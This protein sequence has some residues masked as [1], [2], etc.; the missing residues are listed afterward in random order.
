MSC[1]GVHFALAPRDIEALLAASSDAARLELIQE[2]I[3]ERYLDDAN[4]YAAQTD[5]AWDA[6]HR[7][8]T[9]GQLGYDNGRFPLSHVILG[10]EPLYTSGD[11]IISLKTVAEVPAIAAAL[12]G[13]S[14]EE[15][16]AGYDRISEADYGVQLSEEDF[17]YTWEWLSGLVP[18]YAAAAAAGRP[19]I[20][21]ADQ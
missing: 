18:F 6:I 4:P 21:T 7:A 20:F 19:V 9:D 16:R 3:E 12:R 13:L 17:D 8:L 15:V 1:L 2:D 10:G 14:R 11:Y 5:K